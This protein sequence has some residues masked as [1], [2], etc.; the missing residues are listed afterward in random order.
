MRFGKLGVAAAAAIALVGSPVLAQATQ[1]TSDAAR[2]SASA[3]DRSDLEGASG[4]IIAI[5]AAGAI[6]AGII[7]AADNDEDEPTSP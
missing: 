1:S 3:A 6:I 4:I 5:L 2:V 7:I